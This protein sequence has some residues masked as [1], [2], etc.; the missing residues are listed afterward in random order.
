M[1]DGAREI[2]VCR[3]LAT[4]DSTDGRHN[5]IEVR[6]VEPPKD[7]HTRRREFENDEPGAALEN[8]PDL[9]QRLIEIGDVAEAK[10]DD[11][12]AGGLVAHRQL[13]HVCRDGRDGTS[14]SLVRALA[15]HGFCEIG[16]EDATYEPLLARKQC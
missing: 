13:E 2:P 14:G 12:P 8:A 11:R 9:G 15:K 5:V 1:R 6:L 10:R 3:A 4:D 16:A 7:G